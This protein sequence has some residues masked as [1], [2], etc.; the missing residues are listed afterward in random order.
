MPYQHRQAKHR[1][2]GAE[3]IGLQQICRYRE[4]NIYRDN[5]APSEMA[6]KSVEC[7]REYMEDFIERNPNFYVFNAVIHCDE[8]TPHLHYDF[9][10]F[11]NGYKTGMSQQQGIAKALEQ[12]GYGKR[13]KAYINFTQS[14]RQAFREICEAHGIEV[15]DEQKGRGFTF[16]TEQYREQAELQKQNAAL[17]TQYE[18]LQEQNDKLSEEKDVKIKQTIS[19]FV[20]GKGAKKVAAAEKIIDNAEALNAANLERENQLADREQ[21]LKKYAVEQEHKAQHIVALQ[22]E[23]ESKINALENDRKAL[24]TERKSF[25]AE[26]KSFEQAVAIKARQIADKILR[27]MGIKTNTGHD[28]D[29][30]IRLAVQQERSKQWKER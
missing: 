2:A 3:H 15:A 11:A 21:A 10:P 8:A 9:I 1:Q 29:S 7:L 22:R 24:E 6:Q 30:Q 28:I 20:S 13:E 26:K 18:N 23:T 25:E 19:D 4:R 27:A 16:T 12:M 5:T 17:L 14:E